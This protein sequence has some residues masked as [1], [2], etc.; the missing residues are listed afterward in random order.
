MDPAATP[1]LENHSIYVFLNLRG[2]ERNYHWG[3]FVPTSKPSGESWHANNPSAPNEWTLFYT[4]TD[5]IPNAA[6][7][8]LAFK[9]GAVDSN[10]NGFEKL[11]AVLGAVPT[12][13]E[14]S[15][16]TNEAFG[17]RVWVKDALVAL[18]KAG[19]VRL[20]KSVQE[21]EEAACRRADGL[22]NSFKF[23]DEMV[24]N[25]TGFYSTL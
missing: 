10:G 9:I 6:A 13:G 17:C 2:F 22:R 24:W 8:C 4:K 19:V 20:T 11:R 12:S 18:D 25:D 15:P 14:P 16:N 23:R 5:G 7:L 21:I 3:F 1:L